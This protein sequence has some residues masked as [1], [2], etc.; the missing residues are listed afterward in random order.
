MKIK[1][2]QFIILFL[3]LIIVLLFWQKENILSYAITKY[4]NYPIKFKKISFGT[5]L[6]TRPGL[7]IK[8]KELSLEGNPSPENCNA[9]F[10]YVFSK[11]NINLPNIDLS[12]GKT[13]IFSDL[14]IIKEEKNKLK[15]NLTG[16]VR[17]GP[18]NDAL[19]CLNLKQD[20]LIA[21]VEI[22]KFSFSMNLENG[23]LLTD[24]IYGSGNII[25]YNGKFKLIN[26][27]KPVICKFSCKD[28]KEIDLEDSNNFDTL[29]AN[30]KIKNETI[31]LNDIRFKNSYANAKGKGKIS[32]DSKID[33]DLYLA[34]LDTYL[35]IETLKLNYLLPQGLMP[36][37]IS[38]SIYKPIVF[39]NPMSLPQSMKPGIIDKLGEW[40]KL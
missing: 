35:P 5:P 7:R 22:P 21:L 31:K 14:E 8:L 28:D 40:L 32:F 6:D 9:S 37:K 33:F 16:L 24:S 26:I 36:V 13:K 29:T 38:G 3:L 39:P 4:A 25:L 11:Q 17:K 19:T 15:L 1:K 12:F 30:F 23:K 18:V 20:D 27:I 2:T 10:D 34:G